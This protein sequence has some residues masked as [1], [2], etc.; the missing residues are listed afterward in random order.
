MNAPAYFAF[1]PEAFLTGTAEMSAEEVGCY[2]RLLCFQWAKN[3]LPANDECLARLAGCS[4]NAV[5]AIR[6]KFTTCEDGKLRNLRLEQ[7]RLKENAKS[8]RQRDKAITRW[9]VP[10]SAEAKSLAILYHRRLDTEWSEKEIKAFKRLQPIDAEDLRL[11][12]RYTQYQQGRG[13]DGIHR[14]DL[15]TFLNNFAGEVDRARQWAS[16]THTGKPVTGNG[17]HE[18]P[19]F[20]SWLSSAYPEKSTEAW[21]LIPESVRLEFRRTV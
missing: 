2:I 8:K 18:P 19:G 13:A 21:P 15:C 14:R 11:V 12:I 5:A 4:G 6:S 20:R 9:R 16:R 7:E 3:G 1:Y 17:D 10:S